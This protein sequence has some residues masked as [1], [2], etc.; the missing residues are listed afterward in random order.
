MYTMII[1]N[2]YIFKELDKDTEYAIKEFHKKLNEWSGLRTGYLIERV[3]DWVKNELGKIL[4][5]IVGTKSKEEWTRIIEE[6]KKW[7]AELRKEEEKFDIFIQNNNN[8]LDQIKE[9]L[10]DQEELKR[11]KKIKDSTQTDLENFM[12]FSVLIRV[13]EIMENV[14]GA[15]DDVTLFKKTLIRSIKLYEEQIKLDNTDIKISLKEDD[16]EENDAKERI[17]E[18]FEKIKKTDLY[19]LADKAK[20]FLD[21]MFKKIDKIKKTVYT[22]NNEDGNLTMGCIT[23]VLE[24]NIKREIKEKFKHYKSDEA[25]N[26]PAIDKLK[27]GIQDLGF[28]SSEFNVMNTLKA[29][30]ECVYEEEDDSQ[31]ND[32]K[33]RLWKEIVGIDKVL[34]GEDNRIVSDETKE[35]VINLCEQWLNKNNKLWV[36]KETAG[37]LNAWNEAKPWSGAI[38]PLMR[39]M[40]M[41]NKLDEK[42]KNNKGY[43][44][45]L[46][47][48][49]ITKMINWEIE[50]MG[51]IDPGKRGGHVVLEETKDEDK[52]VERK[53]QQAKASIV[54]KMMEAAE[55][56]NE[57]VENFV[58]KS[59]E[60]IENNQRKNTLGH[61]LINDWAKI[62]NFKRK[63]GESK[64]LEKSINNNL[65]ADKNTISVLF[66]QDNNL[67]VNVSDINPRFFPWAISTMWDQK[68]KK[69]Q[70]ICRLY[71]DWLEFKEG[72]KDNNKEEFK[73]GQKDNNKE[74]DIERGI[75]K[76]WSEMLEVMDAEDKGEPWG[77]GDIKGP[78]PSGGVGVGETEKQVV[79]ES[80]KA[81]TSTTTVVP[82]AT[83]A[84]TSKI[85]TAPATAKTHGVGGAGIKKAGTS[86]TSGAPETTTTDP[87]TTMKTPATNTAVPATNTATPGTKT[88]DPEITVV[89]AS[90]SG[91]ASSGGGGAGTGTKTLTKKKGGKKPQGSKKTATKITKKTKRIAKKP[92][93]R[94]NGKRGGAAKKKRL[95]KR[96]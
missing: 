16:F 65:K 83:T 56:D 55:E 31:E 4:E 69:F 33:D 38:Y 52:E 19:M 91:P 68:D 39:R 27:E 14:E 53:Y 20:N 21:D 35:K 66:D 12:M 59:L 5:D 85:M 76:L 48:D 87:A 44:V 8:K 64:G 47:K 32:Y 6:T 23:S 78:W 77:L 11:W 9:Q 70:D 10:K 88:A 89:P 90:H 25:D 58:Q 36:D 17:N 18:V 61:E 93:G 86:T 7:T 37:V 67:N 82:V 24:S 26:Q 15:G 79:A 42:I 75:E 71:F 34:K 45:S 29:L 2:K 43:N 50:Y 51:E 13:I 30:T 54:G 63:W 96:G 1:F 84:V 3:E 28:H 40:V 92:K 80:K 81:D 62:A 60:E 73:K 94:G 95:R 46:L 49:T 72:Q 22:S 57:K 74:E 41:L